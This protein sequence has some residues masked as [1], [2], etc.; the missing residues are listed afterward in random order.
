MVRLGQRLGQTPRN[1]RHGART[2]LPDIHGVGSHKEDPK[3]ITVSLDP[4]PKGEFKILGGSRSDD[5]NLR[6]SNLVV[7][8]LPI[9][10][11]NSEAVIFAS[12]AVCQATMDIAPADPIEGILIGQLMAANEAALALY[13]KGWQNV[14]VPEYFEGGTKFLQLADKATRTR[15]VVNSMKRLRIAN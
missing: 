14:N 8:A 10:Q 7:G 12:G 9:Q 15:N 4:D 6:L 2:W 5:R 3:R 11:S 13:R 1:G